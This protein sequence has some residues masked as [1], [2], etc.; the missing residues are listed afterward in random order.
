MIADAPGDNPV[1]VKTLVAP[2]VEV[3]ATEPVLTV[4]VAQVKAAS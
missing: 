2:E 4:G 3:I 1:T